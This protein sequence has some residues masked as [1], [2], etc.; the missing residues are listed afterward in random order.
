MINNNK[1]NY[2]YSKSNPIIIWIITICL[3]LF[4]KLS[5]QTGFSLTPVSGAD[6]EFE[7][8]ELDGETVFRSS[9]SPGTYAIYMYFQAGV[10]IQSSDAYVEVVY[11]DFGKGNLGLQFNSASSDY[12]FA[13]NHTAAD[14]QDTQGER[15]AIFEL[16]DMDLR[17][18][19]N[20][21]ADLRLFLNP[22]VQMHIISATL[23][24]GPSPSQLTGFP[25]YLMTSHIVSTSVFHWY[26][27]TAGQLDG[28][29]RPVEGR[30]NWTGQPDWWKT[31]IKQMMASNIDVLWVHLMKQSESI[32]INLFRALAEMRAEGYD[33]PKV[34]PFL[35]PLIT[36][37][38][39]PNIDLA[40]SA[41]KDSLAAQYIRFFNQYFSVNT[42]KYADDY[43]A[44]IDNRIILDTW[45]VHLNMDN[46]VSLERNDL[47]SRLQNAFA[48]EHP[49]FNNGIYMITTAVSPIVFSFADE[50]TVQ[51]EIND[52]FVANSFNDLKTVQL[53]GGYWDQNVRTPG[54]FLAR[55]GG[56]NYQAAWNQVDTS[57]NRIYIESWNE[58]DEGTGIY[59]GY[60]GAPFIL[61]G[62]DNP[63]TDTWSQTDDPYEYIKT[64]AQ[65]AATFNDFPNLNSKIISHSFP[66]TMKPGEM[67]TVRVTIRNEG[68]TFW[69]NGAGF[70]FG[71][72][73]L[74]ESE[75]FIAENKMINDDHDDIPIFGGI[76]RGRPKIFTLKITAPDT[77]GNY[78]TKWSMLDA[79]NW[80]G[81]APDIPIEVSTATAIPNKKNILPEVFS[82]KQNYPNPFNPA[83]SIRY[84]LP[85]VQK[86]L[87]T[88]YDIKGKK[89]ATLEN[90]LMQAGNHKVIWNG[91]NSDDDPVSS[92]I[93]IYEIKAGKKNLI[94]KMMLIR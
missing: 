79:S 54:D 18:A 8:I 39:K 13:I 16:A 1:K 33:V 2:S 58:Y 3:C 31:Q 63:N 26:V 20:L 78:N 71:Q 28:P 27:P 5:A 24:L 17:Q 75:R 12:E 74:D 22:H 64:T 85:S 87:L 89:V 40:T 25:S 56:A 21:G 84:S 52:Y 67:A 80:F 76:F 77:P 11:R 81:E 57:V 4:P 94:K 42:D 10:A 44:K 55:D 86:V 36:W 29:W 6:G 69:N 9:G 61:P 68:N 83:T 30:E 60:T 82:L 45:H 50:R 51:F 49:V 90:G 93:Y 48:A 43:L 91:K 47:E 72:I 38:E 7:T 65:G 62:S 92:G 14:L 15:I 88:V 53:K 46:V 37:H 34:A 23:Y 73:V 35:D 70:S 66:D 59:A 32:R 19:Q 41:G